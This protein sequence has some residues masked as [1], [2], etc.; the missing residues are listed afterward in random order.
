MSNT[1]KARPTT[2]RKVTR[3]SETKREAVLD[4]GLRI[5]VEGEVYD[6]RLGD[7]TPALARELRAAI[8]MG[9]LQLINATGIAPDVDLLSAFVW[10]ARRIRGEY[11]R[12][13]D[14]SVSYQAM[15]SDGFD[16]GFP[17]AEEDPEA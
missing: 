3:S 13:E 14:V 16:V 11:V 9:P 8:G 17:E 12:I 1:Q 15:L 7:V 10:L 4:S 5:T 2:A 6:V